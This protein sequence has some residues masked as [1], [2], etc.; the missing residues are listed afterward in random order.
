M[1]NSFI[2]GCILGDGY[3]NKYGALT[4]EHSI[5]QREYVE[6]KYSELKQLNVLTSESKLSMVLRIHPRTLKEHRSLRF[7]TKSLFKPERS[8]FYFNSIKV[9]PVNFYSLCDPQ[10]LAIWYMDDGGR[11]ANTPLGMVLDVSSYSLEHLQ[12]VSNVL[13]EK[14]G[15][16]TSIH[17][18]GARAKKLYF[19]RETVQ[20]FCNIIRPFVIPSMQ[21]KLV[22]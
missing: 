21:Y 20:L 13:L 8:L 11:G 12:I 2:V 7:N 5:E 9:I 22:C 19:K 15:V 16:I 4:I 14:F 6:W 10:S 1:H 17:Y 18:H 3:V